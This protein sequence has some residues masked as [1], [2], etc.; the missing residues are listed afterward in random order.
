MV[1]ELAPG[2]ELFNLIVMKQRFTEDETRKIFLQIFSA[3]EFL[4]SFGTLFIL[5]WTPDTI[6]AW[7]RLDASRHQT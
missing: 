4:V 3:L 2:G 5:A 7:S 1:L 6:P